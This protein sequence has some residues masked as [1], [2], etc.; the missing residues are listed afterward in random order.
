[1]RNERGRP[2]RRIGGV[3]EVKI[4]KKITPLIPLYKR[5]K[6]VPSP[7]RNERGRG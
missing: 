6:I 5:D 2:A 4:R 1:V 3:R 7:V